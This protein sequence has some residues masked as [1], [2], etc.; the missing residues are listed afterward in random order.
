MKFFTHIL[1]GCVRGFALFLGLFSAANIFVSHAGTGTGGEDIWWI[2]MTSLPSWVITIISILAA[3]LLIGFALKPRMGRIRMALTLAVSAVYVF[4]AA[5][6]TSSYYQG[7]HQG[8]FRST[9]RVAVPFSLFV[10][11]MFVIIA[12]FVLLMRKRASRLGE[13]ALMAL[14]FLL[15][16]ALFPLMQMYTFGTTDYT[17]QADALVVL[18]AAAKTDGTPSPALKTRLDHAVQLYEAGLAPKI[19]MSGGIETNG[20]NEPVA[21]RNY[22]VARGVPASAVMLDPGGSDTDHTVV[23]TVPLFRQLGAQTILVDSHFYHLPRIKMAYRAQRVN[24]LT[25]PSPTIP[26]DRSPIATIR[27]IPA[28]WYYWLRSGVRSVR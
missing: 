19:I 14:M 7:L 4:F 5:Q 18:G 10:L 28:F 1:R 6:N 8:L 12:L 20:V 17:R 3:L 13:G 15:S 21:M 23:D 24:V 9:S 2:S 27:E 25:T 22:V 16:F 26:G 11:I